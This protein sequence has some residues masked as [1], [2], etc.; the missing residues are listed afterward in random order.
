MEFEWDEN[1]RQSTL[2][3]RGIDFLD[4]A[5]IWDDPFRQERKDTRFSYGEIRYQTI[6]R[7]PLGVLFVVYT[8]RVYEEGQPVNR[9]ISARPANHKEIEQYRLRTFKRG[10]SS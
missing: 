3:K 2:L 1:K 6:G 5:L 7:G 10:K 8:V 9:I 4:A